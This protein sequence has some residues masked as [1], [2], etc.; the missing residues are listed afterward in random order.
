MF[1]YP[2][3][4]TILLFFVSAAG[5]GGNITYNGAYTVHTFYSS[6]VFGWTDVYTNATVL[7]VAGGGG[8]GGSASNDIAGGGGGAGGLIY[9]TSFNLTANNYTVIVGSGGA[10]ATGY[11]LG[12][13]GTYSSFGTNLNATGGGGGSKYDV[14]ASAGGSGGG[15]CA[16]GG[17][18]YLGY[19]FGTGVTGQGYNGGN[20][21]KGVTNGAGGGGAGGLGGN[22]LAATATTGAAGG[23]G[24]EININGTLANY[25][26]GGGGGGKSTSGAGGCS[27]A[28][29][30]AD[31]DSGTAGTSGQANTGSG[32]GGSYYLT[33]IKNGGNGG[34]GIVIIT[35]LTGGNLTADFI[36]PTPAD[37]AHNN[38][39]VII[40]IS[41]STAENARF[42]LWFDNSTATTA[43]LYNTT[44]NNWTTNVTSDGHYY[45]K[46]ACYR[47]EASFS[48]NT[49]VRDW[50]FD[51]TDPIVSLT[52]N[53]EFKANNYSRANQYDNILNI[54]L[55]FSD[56]IGIYAF[57]INITDESGTG[58][59][60]IDNS[61]LTGTTTLY[62]REINITSWPSKKYIINIS[63]ADTHTATAINDYEV[64][65]VYN[66]EFKGSALYFRT[67]EGNN[68]L[69][70]AKDSINN[71]YD[72]KIDSYEFGFEYE[73]TEDITTD[74]VFIIEVSEDEEIK[75]IIDSPYKAHIVV[76]NK[77]NFKGNWIDFEGLE[78]APAVNCENK[79][80][81]VTFS[82][83][84]T[85]QITFKSIGGLNVATYFYTW[86]RGSATT[87][88][89][90][91]FSGEPATFTFNVTKD[92]SV[93]FTN[94]TFYHEGAIYN[95]STITNT[96]GNNYTLFSITVNSPIINNSAVKYNWNLSIIQGDN[97]TY[98][99]NVTDNYTAYY[100][101]I[102]FNCSFPTNLTAIRLTSYL[103]NL[104]T[105]IYN[106]SIDIEVSMWVVNTSNKKTINANLTGNY[107]YE[108]C[109]NV[110]DDFKIDLYSKNTIDTG[111]THRYYLYNNSINA[112]DVKQINIYNFNDTTLTDLLRITARDSDTYQYY[113]N[114]LGWLERLYV[115]EGV[116]RV[117]QMDLSD[118]YG[119]LIYDVVEKSADYRLKFYDTSNNLLKTSDVLRFS[120]DNGVCEIVS[121]IT[122]SGS[123]SEEADLLTTYTYNN[124]TG[125]IYLTWADSEGEVIS[126]RVYIS[127]ETLTGDL[128]LFNETYNGSS[129]SDTFNLSGVTGSVL[130]SIYKTA[131]PESDVISYWID[132]AENTFSDVMGDTEGAF[133][134]FVILVVV[135]IIGI[136]SPVACIIM[137]VVGLIAIYSLGIFSGLTLTIV[138]VS[139]VMGVA[140]G[141]KIRR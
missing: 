24:R 64:S 104:P 63:L 99:I 37:D 105:T 35:Y 9:N 50:F 43:V 127:K 85:E 103:E 66:A 70:S 102:S 61:S 29:A 139:I 41:C 26:C 60:G 15:G 121:L 13:N 82:D 132:L 136:I 109:I 48:P 118:D 119:L 131:S 122:P 76:F 72:K 33:S 56:N 78:G 1:L 133:W 27:Q 141:V 6:G 16:G 86:F 54:S 71:D 55:N 59:W 11:T 106:T 96:T 111:F 68:I 83:V 80:C 125:L 115:A 46:A 129:G 57:Q 44:V 98:N 126:V 123:T 4:L 20:C 75:H 88:D 124:N 23:I 73:K 90:D 28:G 110:D 21:S 77:K 2:A 8:G 94:I 81:F 65:K 117:V 51:S 12:A 45:Y 5:T 107:S 79:K 140:L 14:N 74:R 97:T 39:Q 95:D 101:N 89:E 130:V 7:V 18:P 137:G 53:N 22:C 108:I 114:I 100:W 84:K 47:S 19:W 3:F 67:E 17:G 52:D 120:C 91:V 116:W 31:G 10:G 36:A 69:I 25:S 138:I 49:T 128:M 87:T 135:V 34:S 62:N 58:Y 32:G 93:N 30:G 38:T 134:S 40:N 92:N 42:Y 112:T 113:P